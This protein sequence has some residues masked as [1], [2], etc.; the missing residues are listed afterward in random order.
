MKWNEKSVIFC[1]TVIFNL[2][3]FE[4]KMV[5]FVLFFQQQNQYLESKQVKMFACLGQSLA[6]LYLNEL[7]LSSLAKKLNPENMANSV[8]K[9]Q[10]ETKGEISL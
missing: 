8:R 9:S 1:D 2:S 6:M 3:H 4:T 5:V 7:W 10:Y